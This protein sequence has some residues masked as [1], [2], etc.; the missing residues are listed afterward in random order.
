MSVVQKLDAARDYI[1]TNFK[2]GSYGS[3][4]YSWGDENVNKVIDCITA[5]EFMG[6]FAK[7][8][9]LR[10]GYVNMYTQKIYDYL[11]EAYSAADGHIYNVIMLDG[12]WVGYVCSSRHMY[13][14]DTPQ[15]N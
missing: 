15:L 11:V 10:V 9:G 6:D 2:Y 3:A 14:K 1:K 13:K 12:S 8:L 7:D 5:S 4:V